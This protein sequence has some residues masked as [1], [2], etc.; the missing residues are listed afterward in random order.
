MSSLNNVTTSDGYTGQ[1]TLEAPGTGRVTMHVRNAAVYYSLARGFGASLW[2]DD[3]FC[4]PGSW[5]GDR[6]CDGVRVR[7]AVPG[8]PAQVTVDAGPPGG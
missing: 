2:G 8:V 6:D 3:I 5:S 7:S 1:T 4:P